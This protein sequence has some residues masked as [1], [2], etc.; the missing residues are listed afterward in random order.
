MNDNDIKRINELYH[1]SKKDGLTEHEKEEQAK[2]RRDYIDSVKRN[3]RGSLN[4]VSIL[5]NDG[6]VTNLS[7]K[8]N[9]KKK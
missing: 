3:M 6:S 9:N 4:N 1:K 5:N 7:D 8:V 2:L